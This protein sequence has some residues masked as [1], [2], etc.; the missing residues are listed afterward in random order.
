MCKTRFIAFR[1]VFAFL[2]VGCA[3]ILA[4]TFYG[5][6]SG[7]VSDPSGGSIPR[8][9]VTL[10]NLGTNVSIATSTSSTGLYEFT[11]LLPGRYR[12]GVE[13]AGFKRFVREPIAVEVQQAARI[14]ITMSL[15]EVTQTVAVTAET[16]LLQPE[17]S[18]LG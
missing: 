5:S 9:T 18:S 17:T 10:T 15:G 6:I 13:N 1:I 8:A 12:V 7:L 11:N 16:P 14:D 4:Q 3:G 2:A